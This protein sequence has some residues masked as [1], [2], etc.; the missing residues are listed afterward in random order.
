MNNMMKKNK[1]FL[2]KGWLRKYSC[3]CM[4][5]LFFSIS[6]HAQPWPRK[7]EHILDNNKRLTD[8]SVSL[9]RLH[10]EYDF[11]YVIPSREN[12]AEKMG[13]IVGFLESLQ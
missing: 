6:L 12:I 5:I 3:F 13:R 10:S 1:S 2:E 8:A 11:P 7:A 9:F 4:L